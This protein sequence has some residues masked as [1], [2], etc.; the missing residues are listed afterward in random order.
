MRLSWW[1]YYRDNKENVIKKVT[2]FINTENM[3]INLH[4]IA[5][6]VYQYC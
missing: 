3:S 6:S 2:L 1:F 4:L 5:R